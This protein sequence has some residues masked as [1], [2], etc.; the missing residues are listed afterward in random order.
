MKRSSREGVSSVGAAVEC[1]AREVEKVE[2]VEKVESKG[3]KPPP[4]RIEEDNQGPDVY[5]ASG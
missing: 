2:K 3:T 5:Y 1:R 4:V